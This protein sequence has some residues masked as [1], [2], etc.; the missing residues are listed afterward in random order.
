[1]KVLAALTGVGPETGLA[2]GGRRLSLDRL[3]PS[4]R[5]SLARL[6]RSVLIEVALDGDA[7]TALGD[8]KPHPRVTAL[9]AVQDRRPHLALEAIRELGALVEDD[10]ELRVAE[11]AALLG[12]ASREQS[13]AAFLALTT[14]HALDRT[15]L[16][17]AFLALSNDARSVTA[18]STSFLT[19]FERLLG[20]GPVR[21]PAL[22]LVPFDQWPVTV[23]SRALDE[24]MAE[25]PLWSGGVQELGPWARRLSTLDPEAGQRAEQILTELI[26]KLEK[27]EARQRAKTLASRP[28]FS[29]LG[30]LPPHLV[31]AWQRAYADDNRLGFIL[32]KKDRLDDLAKLAAKLVKDLDPSMPRRA[33]QLLPFADDGEERYF[34]L[35]LSRPMAGDFPVLVIC[36][37][38]G[39][40][41]W[42]N[43]PSTAAWLADDGA[44]HF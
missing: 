12:A 15:T 22:R 31:E 16:E 34:V 24:A 40:E 7:V 20:A 26:V 19:R 33:D 5:E 41:S 32:V 29:A 27:A 18:C 35:D 13:E 4:A 9:R 42:E 10:L 43:S 17:R 25:K 28:D 30:A 38:S 36:K 1:M 3:A 39:G 14:H 23:L 21:C 44:L 11:I 8:V 2:I 6:P 37:G